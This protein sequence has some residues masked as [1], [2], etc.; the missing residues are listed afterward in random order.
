MRV[1]VRPRSARDEIQGL[2][3]G[4]LVVRI[5]AAPVDGEANAAL[6]QLLARALRV[7]PSALELVRGQTGRDKL[8]RVHGLGIEAVRTRLAPPEDTTR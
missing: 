4:A 7:P 1:R 3:A 6:R 2:Q 8:L 5:T